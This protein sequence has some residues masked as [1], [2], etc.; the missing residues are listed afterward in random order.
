VSLVADPVGFAGDCLEVRRRRLLDAPLIHTVLPRNIKKALGDLDVQGTQHVFVD[1]PPSTWPQ[2]LGF[3]DPVLVPIS[4]SVWELRALKKSLPA[5]RSH[6]SS[7]AFVCCRASKEVR[8][9]EAEVLEELATLGQMIRATMRE[10]VIYTDAFVHEYSAF[11]DKRHGYP[12]AKQTTAAAA[13]KLTNTPTFCG[14]FV[15]FLSRG[16]SAMLWEKG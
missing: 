3:A 1:T 6:A 4:P 13:R 7:L 11:Q 2:I 14:F 12:A 10:R 5:I 15:A 16:G 8:R 9:D